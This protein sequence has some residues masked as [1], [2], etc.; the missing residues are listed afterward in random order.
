MKN[1]GLVGS[2]M[3]TPE[4][5]DPSIA[6]GVGVHPIFDIMAGGTPRGEG[7]FISP[8]YKKSIGYGKL[9]ETLGQ[10]QMKRTQGLSEARGAQMWAQFL[11]P[12][13]GQPGT[14]FLPNLGG[15]WRGY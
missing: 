5:L 7:S 6:Q 14:G 2:P 13:L 12:N 10:S 3:P 9:M 8:Q 15:N 1:L 11:K 4:Q